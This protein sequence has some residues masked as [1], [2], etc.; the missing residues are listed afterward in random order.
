[1]VGLRLILT[2][3]LAS[4]AVFG[5]AGSAHAAGDPALDRYIVTGPIPDWGHEGQHALAAAAAY[6][7]RLELA[8]IATLGLT[9]ATAT[10]GWIDPDFATGEQRQTLEIGLIGLSGSSGN[11]QTAE[12]A[13]SG[14]P[15]AASLSFCTGATDAAPVSDSPVTGIS[16]AYLAVCSTTPSGFVPEVISWAQ[17]NVIAIVGATEYP[18]AVDPLTQQELELIALRQYQVMPSTYVVIGSPHVAVGTSHAAIETSGGDGTSLLIAIGFGAVA[19]VA[20]AVVLA[21]RNRRRQQ[22][23]S[24]IRLPAAGWYP[25]PGN[26]AIS[27]YWTG[28]GWGP[29]EAVPAASSQSSPP[30]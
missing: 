7:N 27:R 30:E 5:W 8:A 24:E 3:P 28:S 21:L 13:A 9:S 17:S 15:K 16:G 18:G 20:V 4:L 10:E 11:V 25:G 12:R 22:R 26:P 2:V 14:A 23:P 29:S 1:M 6:V 19:V